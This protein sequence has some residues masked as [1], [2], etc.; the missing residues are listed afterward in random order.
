MPHKPEDRDRRGICGARK[1]NGE[2]C[3]AFAGQG[4]DHLGIGRCKFHGGRTKNHNLHAERIRV[5][6]DMVRFGAPIDIR[7]VDAL[8]RMLHL[9]SGHAAWLQ[10]EIARTE[11]LANPEAVQLTRL[12]A[13]ER[14]RIARVAKSCLDA[15]VAERQVAIAEQYG[16][17]L[18]RVL[19]A[20]FED[21]ELALRP[22]QRAALPAVTA[23][24]IR[25][26]ELPAPAPVA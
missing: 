4:T 19:R 20:I 13:E 24:Y 21:E 3:R 14:D 2:L 26:L 16:A 6:R 8:L 15:G 25:L 10:A 17:E 5:E 23:R 9:A 7:P 22:E 12:Y 11:D 1:K 18:A